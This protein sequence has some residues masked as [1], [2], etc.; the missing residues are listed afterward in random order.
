VRFS[1]LP[2]QAADARTISLEYNV[3]IRQQPQHARISAMKISGQ[4]F[5]L[6]AILALA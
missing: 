5:P 1:T 3:T 6:P 4:D 2:L